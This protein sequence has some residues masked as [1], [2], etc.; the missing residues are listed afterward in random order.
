MTRIRPAAWLMAAVALFLLAV[1]GYA[2]LVHAFP[3]YYWTQIDTAVYRDGGIA[4]RNQPAM[5]YALELGAAKLPFTY[6]PFA[7]L[8]FAAGSAASFATW[9]VGLA[10]LTI[11]LLPVVAYLSLGLAGRPAGLARAAAAF[12]IGAVGL[13]LEP[14]AMTLFFGQINLVLLAL[15]VGDLALPDRI[16]GK[17][18]GIGLAAGIKLTPLIFIPYLLFTRRVKAAAVSAL[19]FAVTVGLGSRCCRTP[20][21]STGAGSSPGRAANPSTWTTSPLTVSY[22]ALPTPGPTR[23]R[24]GWSRRSS[25]ASPGS[26][27]RYWRVGVATSYSAW[28]RARRPACWCPRSPGRTTTFTWYRHLSSPRTGHGASATGS[29]AS[30]WWW[31][32]LAGGRCLLAT[33]AATTLRPSCCRAGSCFSRRTG[34]TTGQSSSPGVGWN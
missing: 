5:L 3:Q 31:A 29:S 14:V 16:K 18:I 26:P 19:T 28:L 22:C 30:R 2:L 23:T 33:R 10:V 8:L 1:A 20:L 11:G 24:T 27:P 25:S 6:T 4:V 7:A 17:G 32:C 12:A 9:Q 13:W 34:A 15:V 21:R